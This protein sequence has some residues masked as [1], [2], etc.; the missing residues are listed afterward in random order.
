MGEASVALNRFGLGAR[1]NDSPITDPRR[2][3]LDQLSRYN[4]R[5]EVIARLPGTP[6]LIAML[7]EAQADRKESK[8]DAAQQPT[9]ESEPATGKNPRARAG[10]PGPYKDLRE[11]YVAAVGARTASALGSDTP[12][13]ERLVH[14]WSN[15]FAISVDKI[16]T[17]GLAGAFEFEAIRPNILGSFGQML[18]EVERHPAMLL[19]LDQAQSIGPGSRLG[20]RAAQRGRDRGL[21]ENLA[22][23]ILELHTLGVRSGYSQ[24]DVTEFARA[25]TGWTVGGLGRLP[26]LQGSGDGFTFAEFIHEPGPR[27]IMG[28]R[29]DQPGARQAQAVLDDLAV[30]PA[31]ARHIATKLARHFA[32]DDPPPALVTRLEQAYL[33]SGGDLP[34]IYR[35]LIEAPE[36]WSETATKFRTPWEWTIAALRGTGVI[37]LPGATAAAAFQQLGQAVWKP[38]SPAGYD[39]AAPS[40]AGPDALYRRIEVAQRIAARAATV[41]ARQ[42]SLALFP[43]AVSD[44]TRTALARAESGQQA[45]ALLL[46]SPEMMRR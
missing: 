4:P 16:V 32:A 19:Y 10:M 15:H 17:V 24:A 2:W 8:A 23:E 38:G 43:G 14:F 41:D 5:P 42:L 40:W 45:L 21:N 34:T 27:T 12:F 20:R 6:A 13:A 33:R 1:G 28:K 37:A 30:H 7:R 9:P 29:Y 44:A 18:R 25:L 26:A 39:D 11:E 46:A 31:T 35:A 22:R 36:P 3:L